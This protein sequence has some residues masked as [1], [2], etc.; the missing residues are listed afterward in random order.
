[1]I[2]DPFLGTGT[3]TL[4]AMAAGR[5]SIGF[6]IDPNFKGHIDER[7]TEIRGVTNE[8]VKLR[9]EKHLGFIEKRQAETKEIK[10]NNKNYNFPVVTS[11]ETN[12]CIPKIKEIMKKEENVFE[13]EHLF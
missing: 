8:Y 9:L 6:E 13:I 7:I 1:V 2:L 3:T 10:Y 11:Q 12:L 5:N 4:A